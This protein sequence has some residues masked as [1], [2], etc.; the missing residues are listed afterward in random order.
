M[1]IV[2]VIDDWL[3]L[4]QG[5]RC[6]C[7]HA[8]GRVLCRSCARALP[9]TGRTV[10]PDP[11]PPGLAPVFAAGWYEDPLR[12]LLLAH[13]ERRAFSLARPLGVLLGGVVRT[14]LG[15]AGPELPVVLVPV[16]SSPAVVRRRGH[17]PV[18]RMVA[19]A[20]ADLRRRGHDAV[21]EPLLQ[22]RRRVADQAGLDA[23]GRAANLAGRLGPAPR[24]QRRLARAGRPVLLVLCDDV[25][26]TGATVREGQR[27]LRATGI[28]VAAIATVAAT[29]K[30]VPHAPGVVES[31]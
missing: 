16:P 12:P 10:L 11:P 22:Q 17:D 19:A 13:K 1:I 26:T 15:A 2:R 23:G 8:P 4:A 28:R 30:R 20:A 6:A 29:R 7:C 24:V 14:A 18:R 21:A 9:G 27:A 25:I 31:S 3:D 5:S